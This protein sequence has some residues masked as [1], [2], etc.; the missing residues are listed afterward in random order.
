MSLSLIA[1][2]PRIEEPSNPIP[3]ANRSSVSSLSGIEKCC[4]V[5][6]KSVN[7]RSTTCTPASFA[8]RTTSAG[9]APAAGFAPVVDVVGS[10]V[11]A[12]KS[13]S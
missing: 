8:F 2:N 7:R 3:S 1:W 12:I 13:V 5:P 11:A 6:G 4:H 10:N 9:D